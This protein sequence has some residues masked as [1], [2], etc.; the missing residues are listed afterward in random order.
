[1]R[2]NKTSKNNIKSHYKR[3]TSNS[4]GKRK[5]K[6]TFVTILQS[7]YLT[8][9]FYFANNLVS[10]ASACAF[11]FLFSFIPTIMM[12][13]V[14]LIRVLHAS[15]ETVTSFLN[16]TKIFSNTFDLQHLVDSILS[17]KTVTNFEVVLGLAI[18]WMARRFFSSVM[19]GLHSIFKQQMPSR[20]I[21]SQILIFTGE[22]I[23]VVLAATIIFAV[24]SFKT[25]RRNPI[26]QGI[27][28][29][30]PTLLGSFSSQ[31]VNTLPLFIIFIIVTV[32]YKEESGTNPSWGLSAIAAAACTFCFW[33]FQ[34]LM[35]LFINVNRYNLLYGVLSNVIVMLLEVYFFFMMFLFFAQ[36]IFVFQFFDILLLGELYVLPDRDDTHILA[37][38]KRILFINPDY[39]I[40]KDANVI[41]CK[42][43]DYIY[44]LGD[45]D[46]DAYYIARGTVQI[47]HKNSLSYL[48]RG[49]F[50]GEEA[51]ILNETRNEDA[52]AHTDVE[53]VRISSN[54]FLSLL[55]KNPAASR[56]ALSQISTYYAKVYGRKDDYQL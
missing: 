46:T 20:P 4:T 15:P 11:G 5:R 1:M 6:F 38:L 17:V 50:F 35:G 16:S 55:E 52:C 23:I 25:I 48:E 36:F 49:S 19:S 41:K 8:G 18:I 9:N 51:C 43:G 54:T 40:R 42:K 2:K 37:T 31:I 7:I 34:R 47:M 44:R 13:L 21:A 56:K 45:A 27:V 53:I 10:S 30:F 28:N 12:I 14:V 39:L 29:S 32:C 22:A 33:V 3:H 26:F 24:I